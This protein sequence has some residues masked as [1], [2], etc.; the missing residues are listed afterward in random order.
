MDFIKMLGSL[1]IPNVSLAATPEEIRISRG[2]VDK[3]MPCLRRNSLLTGTL[4]LHQ[5]PNLMGQ[6][7]LQ[8]YGH[9]RRGQGQPA[10]VECVC[11]D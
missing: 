9:Y 7:A 11:S 1:A 8:R 6:I 5:S 4:L 3:N 10:S 2:L